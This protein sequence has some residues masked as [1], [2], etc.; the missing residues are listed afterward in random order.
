[1]YADTGASKHVGQLNRAYAALNNGCHG[2][3]AC[4]LGTTAQPG[5]PQVVVA[6]C[7]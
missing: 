6:A 2:R 5:N 4:N 7:V 1:M 3:A